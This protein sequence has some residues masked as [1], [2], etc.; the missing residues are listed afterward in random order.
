MGVRVFDSRSDAAL[1]LA[2]ALSKYRGRDPLV[3]GVPRGAL[4]MA[5]LIADRLGG[6]VDVVLVR[7]L[8][9][10]NNPEFAI[11]AVDE[12][13]ATVLDE[14]NMSYSGAD[15]SYV[16]AETERQRELM[17]KRRIQYTAHRDP[18]EPAGRN[19]IVIDDGLATGAT[20][21]AALK[22]L[23][24]H[25]PAR[26]VCAVPVAPADTVARVREH[27][28]ELVC[29]EVP[30]DFYAV[31]QF[32]RYFPQVEDDEV[33]AALQTNSTSNS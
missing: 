22:A 2:D 27:C 26:L 14:R 32:Y 9:A 7:K 33:I 21:I 29:L 20:M 19:V 11:G 1:K 18:I 15:P 30:D 28:D 13:G 6:T 25:Q 24:R 16:Q 3:L 5:R 12:T 10:P 31:G 23:R 4:P 17:R 8:G